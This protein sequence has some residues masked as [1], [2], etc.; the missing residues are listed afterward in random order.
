MI[1]RYLYAS[2]LLFLLST[3]AYPDLL[4]PR[5]A[6]WQY[7]KGTAEASAP[8]DAWRLT[9]F[10]DSSWNTGS[11]PIRYGDGVGGTI[12]DD[13]R[14]NYTS[15]FMRRS[16]NVPDLAQV[17][18]LN[19]NVDWDDGYLLWINGVLVD[20]RNPPD[21]QA[22]DDTAGGSHES[23][24]YQTFA[25]PDPQDYL[26]AGVNTIAIQV[27]NVTI[28]SSDLLMD[29]E[30]VSIAPDLSAPTVLSVT[31]PPGNVLALSSVEVEFSETVTGVNASDLTLNGSSAL[32]VQA[33]EGNRYVFTFAANAR[34]AS[35]LAWSVDHGI[36]DTA[37]PSNPFDH[38][39]PGEVRIY[40]ITDEIAP[41]ISTITPTPGLALRS[42]QEVSVVFSEAVTN[43]DAA[44]LL[45]GGTPA[46]SVTGNGAGPYLFSFELAQTGELPLSWAPGHSIVDLASTPNRFAA[47]NWFYLI[48]P[49]ASDSTIRINEFVATNRNGLLDEDEEASDWI[50]LHNFGESS[51]NVEGWSLTDNLDQPGKFVLPDRVI[52]SN[53][54]L[55]VFASGKDRSPPR[56]GE[57][58]ANFKLSASGE[59]LG[60][61]SP[62]LPR[63]VADQIEPRFPVQRNDYSYGLD[64]RRSWSYFTNPTPGAANGLSV[65][66]G[67]LDPPHVNVPRGFYDQPFDLHLTSSESGV[68]IRYTTDG[69]EPTTRNG[70]L[71]TEPIRISSTSVIRAAAFGRRILPSETVTHSYFYNAPSSIRSLPVISLATDRSNLWGP[72]GIQEPQNTPNRGIAWERPVSAELIKRDNS[73]FHVNCGLRVQGGNYIRGR[74]NPNGGLPASKYSFRLYFRGDYGPTMLHYPF[75]EG[76]EV[77]LFDRITLRAGMN[78]HSNPFIVDEYVRRMQIESDNIGARGTF[79][80]LFIN[81]EYKGYYNPT[82]RIDDDFMRSWHGGNEEWDVIAQFGEVREGD[83]A[84]WN[85]MKNVVLRNMRDSRN[86]E[87]AQELLDI[88]NFI[89]YL[90]V[91]VYGGTGDWP[92]NNW[93]AA[94][95]RKPGAKF[96]FYV[97]DAEWSLGNQGRSVSGNTLTGELG[98]G[99]DIAR[100]YQSLRASPDFRLRW[101]DRFHRLFFNRGA[102]E[103]GRNLERF[104]E[105]SSELSGVLPG[106]NTSIRSNWVPNRRRTIIEHMKQADLYRSDNA[107]IFSRPS[108]P[109]VPATPLSLNSNGGI[110]HYTS[111]GSDPRTS[112]TSRIY[113]RPFRITESQH[114]RARTLQDNQWSALSESTFL[115]EPDVPT[116]RFS[117]IMY[118]PLG[119][120]AFEFIELEN[121]GTLPVDLT[122]MKLRGIEFT[123]PEGAQLEPGERLLLSSN[124]DPDAFSERYPGIPVFGTFAGNLSNG[125]ERLALEDGL[126]N[127][128]VSVLYDDKNGWP[129]SADGDGYSLVLVDPSGDDHDPA[130]WISSNG[131]NGSPGQPEPGTDEPAV[132]IVEVLAQNQESVPHGGDFPGFIELHNPGPDLVDLEDWSLSTAGTNLSRFVFPRGTQIAGGDR[133]VIWCSEN[134]NLPGLVSSFSLNSRGE[135]LL[136]SDA[137]GNRVEAFSF[138]L[139]VP[140]LSVTR[141][142]SEWSL[143]SPSPGSDNQSIIPLA[144]QSALSLNEWMTN[145]I[146]GTSDWLEL[147]NKDLRKPVSLHNIHVRNG[148]STARY[149]SLSFLPPGGHLRLWADNQRGSEH[150]ELRL[151]SGAGSIQLIDRNGL[152]IET[153]NHGNQNEDVSNGRYPDGGS[154]IRAFSR[155][156]SPG[157]PNYLPP[158][159]GIRINELLASHEDAPP[160]WIELRNTLPQPQSVGGYSLTIGTRDGTRWKL[161]D[162]LVIPGN[163]HLVISCDPG[164]PPSSAPDN[165]NTGTPLPSHGGQLFFFNDTGQE[166]DRVLYGAQIRE[167]SIG[168]LS[169]S[170]WRLLSSPTPGAPNSGNATLGSTSN[171]L[172]NE[173]LA[174]AG[175]NQEEFVEL[176]NSG[177]RPVAMQG[178]RLTDDLSISGREQFSIPP[179]SFIGPAGF[180]SYRAD[181]SPGTGHLPFRLHALGETLR[182]Y[183]STG[184]TIIDEVTWGLQERGVSSGR[185]SN[186][187][188]IITPLPF[189]S[190]GGSNTD[191]PRADRDGDGIPD[192][193]ELL[194]NL[195]PDSPVDA[196]LDLDSDRRS[197]LHEYQ[198]NTDPTDPRSFLRFS[199]AQHDGTNFTLKFDA[200]P[201]I[202]YTIEASPDG[203]NWSPRATVQPTTSPRVEIFS[204]QSRPGG[205]YYRLAA[206]RTGP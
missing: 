85:E 83:S 188:S 113:T 80:N 50:E 115:T 49:E 97:W 19:L 3:A 130:N 167:L 175:E 145:R 146:P 65:I 161:P 42:L 119:A 31:P 21:S 25:L 100:L 84:A 6:T 105:L 39:A 87:A 104:E 174:S 138:G 86:Y 108:G 179:L 187:S 202:R 22:H 51:V 1:V 44:D 54:Y 33:R 79:V 136:L 45:A 171:L 122:L 118:N 162:P 110:I 9:G 180:V 41:V 204:D 109:L 148:A 92:H 132:R 173:W 206:E 129:E 120:N 149:A 133:L 140:D 11:T 28:N 62:E 35:T 55:V 178:L 169:N 126:G 127:T 73:G 18:R 151:Q 76:S 59:Y 106:I 38:D 177:T 66:N 154:S 152:G 168:R 94:R 16:F 190:P 192:S 40:T 128:I 165:L 7:L 125:G 200:R 48:D 82:E 195:N 8:V 88:D 13:M 99:S 58:H 170:S 157:S 95:E 164:L 36:T 98:G 184:T 75:F 111:D 196:T 34:G 23:G 181:D 123:F 90:L 159:S 89:D 153:I 53:G 78:D 172:I 67:I 189:I 166:L 91:N 26:R 137:L 103:D 5:N 77:D 69:S 194:W 139:Q 163:G 24:S 29:A 74:Y 114:I 182:L 160:G 156:G 96:R 203:I 20:S 144:P 71:Y 193:W 43:V 121:F 116:L 183:R 135:T 117:E 147:Y 141:G 101:A 27:F 2:S 63:S 198:S 4:L 186:G 17:A 191:N 72:T 60:L 134:Q 131:V 205:H 30:L 32:A 93:R 37:S 142:H 47:N 158:D 57:I 112:A 12:L 197:N 46:T 56:N 10:D 68:L 52:P 102:L 124:D 150:L 15:V 155:S 14:G 185:Q 201:G 199:S 64:S 81:G 176:Y 143:S 107:P 61:F 70:I